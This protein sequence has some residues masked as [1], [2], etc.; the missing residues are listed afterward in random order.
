MTNS[1]CMAQIGPFL[2]AMQQIDS[3]LNIGI[4]EADFVSRVGTAQVNH[5]TIDTHAISGKCLDAGVK[6]EK[7]LNAYAKAA[8]KWS[9]C[10]SQSSC[11]FRKINGFEQLQWATAGLDITKA[12]TEIS[13]LP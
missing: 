13:T 3:R 12:K 1:A 4:N 6:L 11:T 5:D 8:T 7:G 2:D 10:V 9:H